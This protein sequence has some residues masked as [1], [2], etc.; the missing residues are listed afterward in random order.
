MAYQH[1]HFDAGGRIITAGHTAAKRD[2]A[3]KAVL[4]TGAA[5]PL[6]VAD[7]GCAE[8]AIGI[9]IAEEFPN[10]CVTLING[11]MDEKSEVERAIAGC[12]AATR[13]RISFANRW[14]QDLPPGTRFDVTLW[15]AVLHHIL[16]SVGSTK[17]LELVLRSTGRFAVIEVPVGD[18]ALLGLWKEKHGPE[19][20][21]VLA[22]LASTLAWLGSKCLVLSSTRIDYGESSANLHRYAFVCRMP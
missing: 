14:V 10:A 21:E 15:F 3:R 22:T 2:I 6:T 17:T 8:G 11:S 9:A 19:P 1:F 12:A 18:D 16:D 4:A 20:Y 7:V 5:G 13:C